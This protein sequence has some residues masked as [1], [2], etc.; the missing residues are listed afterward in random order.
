MTDSRSAGGDSFDLDKLQQLVEMMEKHDLRE[1]TLRRGDQQ[2]KLKRGAQEVVHAVPMG[3]YAA[4]APVTPA[5]ATTA[6]PTATAKTGDEGLL[7]VKSPM[8]GTFY[9]SSQPGE[10]AFVKVGSTVK[11]DTVVCLIEAMKFFNPVKA[12]VSGT[13]AKVLIKD[14]DAVE[15]GQVLFL[16]QP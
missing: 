11:S 16:V 6:A 1:V 2:W 12:D 4:P 9:V 8:V 10:P 5:P 14:G 7:Q 3:G 15:Y 13:I